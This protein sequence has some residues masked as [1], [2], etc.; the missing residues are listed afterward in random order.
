MNGARIRHFLASTLILALLLLFPQAAL[1]ESLVVDL[2][3]LNANIITVNDQNA[4]AE[5]LAVRD[6]R[7]V[8]VG[9]TSEA[10]TLIG[11]T[12]RI[13][14]A[15]G[16]AITPGFIDA[17][18]HINPIYPDT[19]PLSWVDLRPAETMDD[20]INALREKAEITPKGQWVKGRRYDLA[21]LGRHPTRW[22]LDKV[23]TE[24]PIM[25]GQ[26][27]PS[28]TVVNSAVLET[29]K[30]T[31]DTPDPPR[32]V[33]DR[34]K[35]GAPTGVC[36]G[37]AAVR[38]CRSGGPPRLQ[39]THQEQ[40]E[41]IRL[42][43]EHLA[44]NGITSVH[45]ADGSTPLAFNMYQDLLAEDQPVRIYAMF[46]YRYL[47]ELKELQL[48]TGFGDDRLKIGSIKTGSGG[49][50]FSGAALY[51]PYANRPDDYGIPPNQ[52]ELDKRIYEI[53]QA[54]FQAAVHAIGD[55]NIDAVLDAIQKAMER[56][57]RA[58]HRHRIEHATLVNPAILK[59]AKQLGVVLNFTTDIYE[60]GDS[61]V[62]VF[63]EKR[64]DRVMALRSAL[65]LGVAAATNSDYG[66]FS[67]NPMLRIQAMVTRRTA[68]GRVYGP[69]QWISVEEAIR[70][71]TLG[72]AYA[73]FEEGIKGSIEVGKLADF[74]ILSK[75]PTKVPPE[76]IKDITV[77]KT[78]IGGMVVYDMIQLR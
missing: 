36:R 62:Q 37:G 28:L 25:V 7:F 17:H 64:G 57:P 31:K 34:D 23:S 45:H 24:H 32:A 49:T 26:L 77:E 53:H 74:V 41:G 56:L 76:T 9:N 14:D 70:V 65:D 61:L 40:L 22:D 18:V 55:R 13:I 75:D 60:A 2:V 38:M 10:Q 58:N 54:G 8:A 33:F 52:E 48:R 39:P 12:T 27:G 4:R 19:S 29:A 30:I 51:E 72:G 59:K 3:V 67:A 68:Q 35:D 71:S 43:L 47:S 78:I 69:E 21:K 11:E 44:R 1:T 5:A 63:G 15:G 66:V 73:A 20:L 50:P 16:K 6:G 46:N 42:C